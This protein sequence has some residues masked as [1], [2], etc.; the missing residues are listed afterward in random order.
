MLNR[1]VC[2]LA[3]GSAAVWATEGGGSALDSSLFERLEF[4]NVGPASMGGRITDVEGIPG[5]PRLVYVPTASGGLLKTTNGGS[6]W[7]PI[8]DHEATT[9]THPIPTPPHT[10]TV[11][12]SV[13]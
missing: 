6:T 11:P 2:I 9:P 12:R 4:R 13:P 10:P 3:V 1:I 7:T 5:N 8:F